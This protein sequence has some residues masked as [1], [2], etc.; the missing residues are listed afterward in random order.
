MTID[1]DDN[2]YVFGI[3]GLDLG[4]E[5]QNG[6]MQFMLIIPFIENFVEYCWQNEQ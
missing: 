5:A 2:I 3:P 6:L 4:T 1:L